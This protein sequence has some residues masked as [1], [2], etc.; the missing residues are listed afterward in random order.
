MSKPKS[1]DDYMALQYE[2]TFVQDTA[3]VASV[4]VAYN[5]ELPGCMA[6]GETQKE[7][8]D[9]LTQARREYLELK[10]ELGHDI[11]APLRKDEML[12]SLIELESSLLRMQRAI[13]WFRLESKPEDS[14]ETPPYWRIYNAFVY[15]QKGLART[16][17]VMK[18]RRTI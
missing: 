6:Q 5:P 12:E 4:I 16:Q 11:P 9:N 3:E 13:E 18:K 8:G 1:I 7:A 10:L 14:T 2:T 15:V 17:R